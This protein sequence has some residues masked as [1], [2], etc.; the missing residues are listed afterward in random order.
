[1]APTNAVER[2]LDAGHPCQV[3][4]EDRVSTSHCLFVVQ[5]SMKSISY[6]SC[7]LAQSLSSSE[8]LGV[9][10]NVLGDQ[11]H[12]HT[13]REIE[14][15]RVPVQGPYHSS[16]MQSKVFGGQWTPGLLNWKNTF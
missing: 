5:T 10:M 1:M 16:V 11:A 3:G 13:V 4:E 14:E 12:Q 8:E 2:T 15:R 7:H 9:R 6:W